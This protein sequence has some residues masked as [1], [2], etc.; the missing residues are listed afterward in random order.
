MIFKK[1]RGNDQKPYDTLLKILATKD[2]RMKIRSYCKIGIVAVAAGTFS[3]AALAAWGGQCVRYVK[4]YKPGGLT[5]DKYY[6]K[7]KNGLPVVASCDAKAIS[8]GNCVQWVGA[9][10]IWKVLST[11]SRGATPKV[12]SVLV[13]DAIPASP[14][15]HVAVVTAV[16]GSVVTVSHSNWEGDE[17]ISGGTFTLDGAGGAKYKTSAGVKWSKIYPILG[18][19]YRP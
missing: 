10:D 8:L 19:I 18:F 11:S 17:Q 6:P 1:E 9:K 14:V 2:R 3:T 12:G 13:M 7:L 15:G 5:W 4:N 16:S